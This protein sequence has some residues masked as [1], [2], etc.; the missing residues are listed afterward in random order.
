[1]G[2][3]PAHTGEWV[4]ISQW[5]VEVQDMRAVVPSWVAGHIIK[6][7]ESSRCGAALG[8]GGSQKPEP[9][10]LVK[11]SFLIS[12]CLKEHSPGGFVKLMLQAKEGLGRLSLA[13]EKTVFVVQKKYIMSSWYFLGE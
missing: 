12:R 7:T 10:R 1:M 2:R 9:L 8:H 3:G 6:W 13:K 5:D 11:S 4:L